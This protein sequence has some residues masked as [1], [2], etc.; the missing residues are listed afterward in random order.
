M[1]MDSSI[2]AAVK[3]S[4]CGKYTSFYI[5]LFEAKQPTSRRCNCGNVVFKVCVTKGEIDIQIPCIACGDIHKY[6][7]KVKDVIDKSVNILSCPI[8]G[9]EIAFL[10]KEYFVDD[11]VQR[12]MEDMFELL[13]HLGVIDRT[14][15]W[16]VK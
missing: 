9:M 5:N 8:S 2:K 3:C 11:M 14:K 6:K 1:I 10:G 16:V 7:I 15:R 13:T 4:E 12:Y